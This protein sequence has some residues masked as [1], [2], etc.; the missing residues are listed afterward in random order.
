MTVYRIFVAEMGGF[1]DSANY[2]FVADFANQ[3]AASNYVTYMYGKSRYA[4]K[5]IIIKK[6]SVPEVSAADGI[7]DGVLSAVGESLP[8]DEY[9]FK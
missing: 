6:V 7:V 1:R 9:T 4:R 2:E 5:D 8:V 3:K